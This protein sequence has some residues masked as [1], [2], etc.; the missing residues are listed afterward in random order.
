MADD[1]S[2]VGNVFVASIQE[3]Q[4]GVVMS[5]SGHQEIA[6]NGDRFVV[7]ERGRRYEVEPGTPQFKVMEFERYRVRVEDSEVEPTDQFP[8]SDADHM[9]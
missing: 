5:N 6:A 4:L 8:Q 2:Q 7:L 3:G 9:S 1:A